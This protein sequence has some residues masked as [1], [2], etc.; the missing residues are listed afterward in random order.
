M[1]AVAAVAR[2]AA[3]AAPGIRCNTG[4]VDY[5]A[6]WAVRAV[7]AGNIPTQVPVRTAIAV[8]RAIEGPDRSAHTVKTAI[9]TV[10]TRLVCVSHAP[11]AQ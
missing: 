3:R 10:L 8:T 7:K 9:L 11:L 4:S 5:C 2:A 1:G 6:C